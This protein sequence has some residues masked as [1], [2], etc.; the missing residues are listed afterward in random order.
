MAFCTTALQL[1]CRHDLENLLCRPLGSSF[2]SGNRVSVLPT[3]ESL[4]YQGEEIV[5]VRTLEFYDVSLPPGQST[6]E[7]EYGE[8]GKDIVMEEFA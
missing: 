7:L 8:S 3:L 4:R 2:F 6:S 1:R 5:A